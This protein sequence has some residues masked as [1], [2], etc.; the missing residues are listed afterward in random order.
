MYSERVS[1]SMFIHLIP[2]LL[3]ISYGLYS[4]SLQNTSSVASLGRAVMYLAVIAAIVLSVKLIAD[5]R[6]VFSNCVSQQLGRPRSSDTNVLLAIF[7]LILP[8]TVL[9]SFYAL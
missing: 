1:Q 4:W 2:V 5:F 3:L 7:G 6:S 9:L 8:L